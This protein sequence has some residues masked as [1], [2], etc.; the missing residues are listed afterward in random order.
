M[1][2]TSHDGVST[3]AAQVPTR[4]RKPTEVIDLAGSDTEDIVM[5]NADPPARGRGKAVAAT[6]ARATRRARGGRRR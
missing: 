3:G 5:E 6:A 1:D 4:K 2:S